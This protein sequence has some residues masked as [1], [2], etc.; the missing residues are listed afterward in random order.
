MAGT[1]VTPRKGEGKKDQKVKM[2][3]QVQAMAQEPPAMADPPAHEEE[4][5]PTPG[6]IE[7]RRA[8]VESLEDVGRSPELLLT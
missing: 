7:R 2:W 3:A 1:K 6:G 8:E 5:S 4:A